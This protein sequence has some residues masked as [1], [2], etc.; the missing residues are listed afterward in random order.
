MTRNDDLSQELDNLNERI[1]SLGTQQAEIRKE[2]KV[3]TT[4]KKEIERKL[5]VP[6][7]IERY[8]SNY[9]D[10]IE[11]TLNSL[12]QIG[13]SFD[14]WVDRFG[15]KCM[16]SKDIQWLVDNYNSLGFTKGNYV[17]WLVEVDDARVANTE[18]YKRKKANAHDRFSC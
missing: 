3:L 12:V 5:K 2:L 7:M 1:N 17:G 6:E 13:E 10:S 8:E 14:E 18:F 16:G 9:P 11:H 15:R 4:K